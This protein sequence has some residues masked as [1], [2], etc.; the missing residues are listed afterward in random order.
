M[1]DLRIGSIAPD[2]T[3]ETTQG[4]IHFHDWIDGQYAVLFSHPK[5][6]TPV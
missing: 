6:Y 4:T 2:F 5:D 1:T 3:A